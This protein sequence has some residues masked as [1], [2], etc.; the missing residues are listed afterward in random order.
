MNR[1]EKNELSAIDRVAYLASLGWP[2]CDIFKSEGIRPDSVTDEIRNA[3]EQGRLR[4]RADME[5]AIARAAATG[6]PGYGYSSCVIF[7][8]SNEKSSG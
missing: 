1:E 7:N 4:K 8:A 6:L 5:I 3:I 2:D